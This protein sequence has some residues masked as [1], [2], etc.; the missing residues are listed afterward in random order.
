MN[1]LAFDAPRQILFIGLIE[2]LSIGLLALGIILIYRTSRVFNFA[3]GSIGALS[4]SVLAVT[5]INYNWNYWFGLALALATGA[6]FAAVMELTVI[7]RLFTAPRVIVLVA[8]IGIA[9]LA[10]LLRISLP[11]LG[12]E[13]GARFPLP[14]TG[15]Y[16]QVPGESTSQ[17]IELS[18]EWAVN[19]WLGL[20]GNYTYTDAEDSTG[21]RLLRVPGHDVTIGLGAEFAADWSGDVTLRHVAD[22]PAEFGT[23]MG[24][25]TVVNAGVSYA[26]T[27]NA[28]GYLRIENLLDETYETTASYQ[29]SGR[30]VY[31]G[32]R[33]SF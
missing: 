11:D 3:V 12:A 6:A 1:T 17:G 2:G 22:R 4:A 21:A 18:G 14:F 8:T 30:A 24:D 5:V 26:F 27:D 16:R 15:Q 10:D 32:L 7:T 20:F 23:P 31:V 19:D 25:Y 13:L 33:A 29:A 28:E 9:Q